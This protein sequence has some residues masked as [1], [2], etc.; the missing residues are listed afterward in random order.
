[1]SERDDWE[2]GRWWR[3]LDGDG[4]LWAE[5]SSETEARNAIKSAPGGGTLQNLWVRNESEW[6]DA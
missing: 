6:R 1:M 4:E 2:P 3:V 5:T